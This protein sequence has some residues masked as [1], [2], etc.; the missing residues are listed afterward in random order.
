MTMDPLA[1][2]RDWHF[3]DPVSWWPPAPGW[4]LLTTFVLLLAAWLARRLVRRHQRGAPARRALR[5][6]SALRAG[7]A[8]N[9]DI[10]AYAA[11]LSGLLRRLA[12]ARFPR[13][14]VAGLIGQAWLDFLDATGGGR[15]FRQGPG[16]ALAGLAFSGDGG[17]LERPDPDAL[18]ELVATWI[19]ANRD[20][21]RQASERRLEPPDHEGRTGT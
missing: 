4:W 21:A 7:L 15:A 3:P 19:R 8:A 9:G 14:Q 18:A 6:L 20:P 12:L 16:Q 2:L 13:D 1:D 5:E 11:G 10:R 17:D